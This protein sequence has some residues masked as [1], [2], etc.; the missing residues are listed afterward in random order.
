VPTAFID[1]SRKEYAGRS[2]YIFGAVIF[3]DDDAIDVA[4]R[5]LR[6]ILLDG[7]SKVHWY[8]A[9]DEY[10]QEIM[11]V[12]AGIDAMF[13][14]VWHEMLE[15]DTEERSRRIALSHL[16]YELQLL[17]V[18]RAVLESRQPKQ[19]KRDLDIFRTGIVAHGAHRVRAD[20]VSGRDDPALWAADALCGA[21][22]SRLAFN[23][24]TYVDALG[25]RYDS[26]STRLRES[27]SRS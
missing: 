1:E 14:A 24:R 5:G 13:L 8:S 2:V 10:R 26:I 17:G 22:G 9:V 4:R 3:S 18:D 23:D 15:G 12:V 21:E 19:D 25:D 7:E 6:L 11:A 27:D 16:V 20:H